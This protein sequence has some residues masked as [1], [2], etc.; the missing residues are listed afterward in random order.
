MI[1][2]YTATQKAAPDASDA[3]N[4]PDAP[5]V[6]NAPNVANAANTLY[7]PGHLDIRWY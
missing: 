2:A 1:I 5:N 4:A 7:G 6:L 3:P